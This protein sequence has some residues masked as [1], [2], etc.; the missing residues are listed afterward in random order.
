MTTNRTLCGVHTL[1]TEDNS[2]YYPIAVFYKLDKNYSQR[3]TCLLSDTK[4]E[5]LPEVIE[6]LTTVLD[7]VGSETEDCCCDEGEEVLDFIDSTVILDPLVVEY[8][9]REHLG[10]IHR[11]TVVGWHVDYRTNVDK[12]HG[13]ATMLSNLAWMNAEGE[14][15]YVIVDKVEITSRSHKQVRE[16]IRKMFRIISNNYKIGGKIDLEVVPQGKTLARYVLKE[17][18]GL[19]V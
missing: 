16:A 17:Y 9:T 5:T 2:G 4:Y 6:Y 11:G 1:Q 19:T 13:K 3:E 12:P 15:N 14:V 7:K 18:Y 10:D 8:P